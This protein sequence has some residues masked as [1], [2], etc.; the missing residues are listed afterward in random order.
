VRIA[1]NVRRICP[2]HR[3]DSREQRQPARPAI[4]RACMR[5]LVFWSRVRCCLKKCATAWKR[6]PASAKLRWWSWK[7]QPH[8]ASFISKTIKSERSEDEKA[9]S[10]LFH[11]RRTSRCM[12]PFLK[13]KP[14][15]SRPPTARLAVFSGRLTG[16]IRQERTRNSPMVPEL[17]DCNRQFVSLS[18][19]I[20]FRVALPK[21]ARYA[22]VALYHLL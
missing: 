15:H 3:G 6:L 9:H 10:G 21:G 2:V 17:L 11:L 8:S 13:S 7:T 20:R 12:K 5:S 16:K 1:R 22:R 14:P 19:T 18:N 4:V